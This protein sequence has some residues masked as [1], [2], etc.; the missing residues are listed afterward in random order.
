MQN[1]LWNIRKELPHAYSTCR[2]GRSEGINGHE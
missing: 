1:K 2:R